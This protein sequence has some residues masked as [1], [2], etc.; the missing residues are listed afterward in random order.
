MKNFNFLRALIIL[1]LFIQIPAISFSWGFFAHREINRRAILTLPG[2]MSRFYKNFS[3][4]I[5]EHS[6]D[7][8]KRRHSVPDEA[9]R[10]YLDADVYG[11]SAVYRL[12]RYWKEAVDSLSE[13]TL[14]AYGVLPWHVQRVC[15]Q[16]T[17]AFKEKDV[18][19]IIQLSAE[20]GHYIGDAHVPLHTTINYNGQLTGQEGIHSFW[21]TRLPELFFKNYTLVP[22]KAKYIENTQLEIWNVI[23]HSHSLVDSVLLA[24]IQARKNVPQTEQYSV[25]IRKNVE[26]KRP[27]YEL[28][29]EY[30]R[31]LNDMVEKQ[32]L[33]SINKIGDFWF[34]CWVDA[35]Q[36]NLDKMLKKNNKTKERKKKSND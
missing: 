4:Y 13:D 21:E 34:T 26:V 7:P 31:L 3:Q 36:P 28:S 10:H 19:R 17:N 9:P 35:G 18:E 8:D 14:K 33:R 12:P 32:M 27:S 22:R 2:E 24:E 15:Y 20:M 23:A 29:A 5:S 25:T 11:D 6:V 16:L 1:L 30:N